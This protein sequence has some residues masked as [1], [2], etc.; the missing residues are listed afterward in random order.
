MCLKLVFKF[1][2]MIILFSAVKLSQV[3][4]YRTRLKERERRK[5]LARGYNLIQTATT[6]GKQKFQTPKKRIHKEER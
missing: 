3:E 5:R 6:I 2:K 4:K 1:L